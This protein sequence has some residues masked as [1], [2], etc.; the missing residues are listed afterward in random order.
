MKCRMRNGKVQGNSVLC[1]KLKSLCFGLAM[2]IKYSC[3]YLSFEPLSGQK[4]KQS[5]TQHALHPL[6]VNPWH[7]PSLFMGYPYFCSCE[8]I[9]CNADMVWLLLATSKAQVYPMVSIWLLIEGSV[10]VQDVSMTVW[11]LTLHFPCAQPSHN[12][13]TFLHTA[14]SPWIFQFLVHS[15]F[16]HKG[17]N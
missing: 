8:L 5:G 17:F 7:F 3:T 6:A 4:S 1:T 9:T 16:S 11:T 15:P 13:G 14:E 12:K 10:C 2:Q